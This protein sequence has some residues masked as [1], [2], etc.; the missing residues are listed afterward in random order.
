MAHPIT[1]QNKN[2]LNRLRNAVPNRPA[3]ELGKLDPAEPMS[4]IEAYL[5]L[6]RERLEVPADLYR[7][8][9]ERMLEMLEELDRRRPPV[10]GPRSVNVRRSAG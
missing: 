2:L 8:T 5:V 3:E 10:P 7:D 9:Q 1:Q 6:R 4:I